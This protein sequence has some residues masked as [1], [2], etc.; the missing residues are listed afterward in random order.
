LSLQHSRA[1]SNHHHHHHHHYESRLSSFP[2]PLRSTERD[3]L[4]GYGVS[5]VRV[6]GV[7]NRAGKGKELRTENIR[8]ERTSLG[9]IQSVNLN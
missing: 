3:A 2:A 5:V 4:D 9:I 1:P 7:F 8:L 6:S